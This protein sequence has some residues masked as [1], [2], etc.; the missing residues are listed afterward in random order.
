MSGLTG[1]LGTLARPYT[2]PIGSKLMEYDPPRY[3]IMV[4]CQRIYGVNSEY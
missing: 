2:T 4:V 1:P 3:R